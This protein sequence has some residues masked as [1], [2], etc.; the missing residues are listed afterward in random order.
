[1]RSRSFIAGV[2]TLAL[3]L[4]GAGKLCAGVVMAET[5]TALLP[6]GETTFQ[7]KTI[8]IQGNKQKI[9]RPGIAAITD[10]DKSLIYVIDRNHHAFAQVPLRALTGASA[11][12]SQSEIIQLNRTGQTR[13]IAKQRCTEY[14]ATE[15]NKL[16]RITI[17]A[18][19][20]TS[21]PGAKEV[22][23]FEHKMVARLERESAGRTSGSDS[24]GVMLE[25]RSLVRLR[26]PDPAHPGAY[27]TASVVAETQVKQIKLAQLP[28]DTFE[29]PKGFSALQPQPH[30]MPE[31][32]NGQGNTIEVMA[33]RLLSTVNSSRM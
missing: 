18:C 27:R 8:Y 19:V 30:S 32:P 23:A 33:P 21:A 5:S 28:P 6:D 7:H 31:S 22:S 13:I 16:E 25:K 2:I 4:T 10:L 29:P 17:S 3:L 1:M 20:S 15:A 9:E 12:R 11:G 14:R 24:T 26:V